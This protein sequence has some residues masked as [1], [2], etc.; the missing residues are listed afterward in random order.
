VLIHDTDC[1]MVTFG[2]DEVKAQ[3]LADTGLRPSFAL[4]EITAS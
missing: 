3:I 1:G 4:E 2:D